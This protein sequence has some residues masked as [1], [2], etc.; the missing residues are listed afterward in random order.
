MKRGAKRSK[1]FG[2]AVELPRA[3]MADRL[4]RLPRWAQDY[5]HRVQTFVGAPEVE[6]LTY[7]RDENKML[8]KLVAELKRENTGLRGRARAS[9]RGKRGPASR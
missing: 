8:R 2:Q 6:E 5:V 4:D 1:A 7:L 3:T 9:K